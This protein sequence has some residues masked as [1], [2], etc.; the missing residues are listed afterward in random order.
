MVQF[1]CVARAE[2]DI[3]VLHWISR[4]SRSVH[5]YIKAYW[6]LVL[7]LFIDAFNSPRRLDSSRRLVNTRPPS[8]GK[9]LE[10]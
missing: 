9:M 6:H 5:Y 10:I 8:H 4:T 1:G 3:F 7:D 2:M